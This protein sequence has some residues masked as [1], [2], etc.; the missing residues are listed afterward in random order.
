MKQRLQTRVVFIAKSMLWSLLLYVVMMLAINWDDVSRT[1]SGKN[2]I[3]VVSEQPTKQIP[4]SNAPASISKHVGI[5]KSIVSIVKTISGYT[6]ISNS[7]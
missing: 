4:G 2:T 5:I 6:G 3:A 1:I 7:R